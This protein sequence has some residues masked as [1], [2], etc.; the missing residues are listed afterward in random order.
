LCKQAKNARGYMN[1]SKIIC[2]MCAIAG[3]VHMG[4][5]YAGSSSNTNDA[6]ASA[7]E[8]DTLWK[9]NLDS[10][11]TTSTNPSGNPVK[12]LTIKQRYFCK[13]DFLLLFISLFN[14]F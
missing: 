4:G 11:A 12:T 5:G 1:F 10:K 13:F 7:M 6:K 2:S 8:A 9:D 14:R 3:L